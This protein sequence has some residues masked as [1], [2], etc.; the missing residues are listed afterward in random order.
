[1]L[2]LLSVRSHTEATVN[3]YFSDG[4]NSEIKLRFSKGHN[5]DKWSRENDSQIKDRC[6]FVLGFV[7]A[8]FLFFQKCCSLVSLYM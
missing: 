7:L 1:M 5:M 8:L 4:L 3:T 2:S 6:S